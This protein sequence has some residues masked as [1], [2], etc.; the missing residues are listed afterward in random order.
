MWVVYTVKYYSTFTK[1]ETLPFM[2]DDGILATISKD[3]DSVSL[4]KVYFNKHL[5]PFTSRIP[6]TII[7][8]Y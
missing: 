1:E 3:Y 4:S 2:K 7:M 5:K 6:G 8:K